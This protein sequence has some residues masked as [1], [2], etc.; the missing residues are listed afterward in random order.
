MQLALSEMSDGAFVTYLIALTI[1]GVLLLV[2]A[3]GGFFNETRGT[4]IISGVVGVVFLGYAVYL[5]FIFTGGAV[6]M[7][8]YVFIVPALLIGN[9]IR[10]R[11]ERALEDA[12]AN[13]FGGAGVSS[14]GTFAR[15]CWSSD[16]VAHRSHATS[17]RPSGGR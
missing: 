11:R 9:I 16:E 5:A 15:L 17:S 8:L 13:P 10:R 2:M 12:R 7:P 6:W 14:A 4:R 3:I 1:S